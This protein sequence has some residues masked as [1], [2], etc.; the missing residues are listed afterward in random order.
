MKNK[1]FLG[2]LQDKSPNVKSRSKRNFLKASLLGGSFFVGGS[3]LAHTLGRQ[4][5][6]E[7]T[8][9][10]ISR[11]SQL[12]R[13]IAEQSSQQEVDPHFK[14]DLPRTTM[15]QLELLSH[16]I[17]TDSLTAF[18]LRVGSADQSTGISIAKRSA[19]DDDSSPP[20]TPEFQFSSWQTSA[21]E[22]G[23]EVQVAHNQE[24]NTFLT[25]LESIVGDQWSEAQ[26]EGVKAIL[27]RS[28]LEQF[29][30]ALP[31]SDLENTLTSQPEIST[32]LLVGRSWSTLS[33][34]LKATY[35]AT[36]ANLL[37]NFVNYS[38]GE[39][40]SLEQFA[41]LDPDQVY[42]N[43][44]V[45]LGT[46][47]VPQVVQ[48]NSFQVQVPQPFTQVGLNYSSTPTNS[49]VHIHKQALDVVAE[50]DENNVE[51]ELS[52]RYTLSLQPGLSAQQTV[53]GAGIALQTL[54]L[55]TCLSQRSDRRQMA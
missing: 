2:D 27:T 16:F 47:P 35:K 13:F 6:T 9:E 11:E 51:S 31:T 45:Y 50:K 7:A 15:A 18:V 34:E 21:E 26:G 8:P 43:M 49:T 33:P 55:E 38:Q 46:R 32:Y 39:T 30:A 22:A 24:P 29:L 12:I 41:H 20:L 52:E 3:F 17:A 5:E 14:P 53:Q 4:N 19:T 40:T 28:Q 25:Q 44:L 48:N 42:S 54:G 1:D 23:Y 10:T 36:L 37:E